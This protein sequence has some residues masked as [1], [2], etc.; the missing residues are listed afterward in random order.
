VVPPHHAGVHVSFTLTKWY[1]DLVTE[2]G[3]VA[4]AYWAE[5][6]WQQLRQPLCGLLLRPAGG[7]TPPWRFS[8]RRVAPPVPEE[9]GLRW[10]APPLGLSVEVERLEPG[11]RH[12]LLDSP[13][14]V[15]DWHCELPRAAVRL[16]AGDTVLEGVGYVERLE[17]SLLP[18][19]IPAAEIRWGRFLADGT[20]VTWIDW[21]GA[22]PQRLVFHDRRRVPAETVGEEGLRFG[23]GTELR[24][25]DPRVI[26]DDRLGGLLAPL[27]ALRPLIE[28]IT[29]THQTRWLSR[30][31]LQGPGGGRVEG[32]ALHERVT[33]G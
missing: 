13:D 10:G 12:R 27:E 25:T 16:H 31:A 14:G 19:R 32:W 21:R 8:A 20:S 17:L 7:A 23:P 24:L 22:Y 2:E 4:I 1:L 18:W 26:S 5:V 3:G 6:R 28:P 29:R 11:F 30:G 15:V 9:G 33:R